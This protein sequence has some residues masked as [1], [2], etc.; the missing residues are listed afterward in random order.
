MPQIDTD[1]FLAFV[2]TLKGIEL[3][4]LIEKKPFRVETRRGGLEIIPSSGKPRRETR[5]YVN[6]VVKEF[7]R[8][9]SFDRKHYGEI[10]R[11][12]SYLT[13][14]LHRYVNQG[15]NDDASP[16]AG[17]DHVQDRVIIDP[18]IQ[19]GK[20]VIRGTRVPIARIVGGLAGGM[21]FA[22]VREA[23]GVSDDDIRAALEFAN[24][25]VEK[26]EFH[27]LPL[28]L[29]AARDPAIAAYAKANAMCLIT[30]D[31]GFADIRNYPP[32]DYFG[33]VVL[34]LPRNATAQTILDLIGQLVGRTSIV[35]NLSGRLA[36]A[37]PGRIRLRPAP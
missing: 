26:E 6:R 32:Q 29:G 10:T 33:I 12:S 9:G 16:A 34:E 20:P 24:E 31:F 21:T 2:E 3:R 8:S 11:N 5:E 4:T 30:G 15:I 23:Y 1:Q 14:L 17:R 13:S 37:T 36:I 27:A 22:Q 28:G 7:G 18:E 25:L 19:H 35:A